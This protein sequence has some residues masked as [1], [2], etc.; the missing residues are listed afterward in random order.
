MMKFIFWNAVCLRRLGFFFVRMIFWWSS[1]T[2]GGGWW[3][4]TM[5]WQPDPCPSLNPVLLYILCVFDCTHNPLLFSPNPWVSLL[6]LCFPE[7]ADCQGCEGSISSPCLSGSSRI[8][9]VTAP[10]SLPLNPARSSVASAK[11][12]RNAEGRMCLSRAGWCHRSR[13]TRVMAK[14]NFLL[15]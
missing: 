10:F 3:L 12:R 13:S 4:C 5:D 11:G 1:N 7:A 15:N 6:F 2:S 8:F 14:V 9:W